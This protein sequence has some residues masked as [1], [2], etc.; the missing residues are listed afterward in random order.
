MRVSVLSEL[1]ESVL[2]SLPRH[3]IDR[4]DVTLD[5]IDASWLE[6]CDDQTTDPDELPDRFYS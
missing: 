3:A 1:P 5:E 2:L 6:D 4:L